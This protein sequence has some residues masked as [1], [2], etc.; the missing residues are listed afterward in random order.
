MVA[1]EKSEVI[2]IFLPLCV[3]CCFPVLLGLFLYI[4]FDILT[5]TCWGF[6]SGHVW[7][8]LYLLCLYTVSFCKFGEFSAVASI[9]SLFHFILNLNFYTRLFGNFIHAP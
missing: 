7:S 2:L 9:N 3:S 5:V 8:F 4:V 6:I 1:D